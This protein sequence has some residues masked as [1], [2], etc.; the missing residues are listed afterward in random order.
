MIA[1]M[2]EYFLCLDAETFLKRIRPA[3]TASWRQRSFYPCRSLCIDL[4]AA[5][6]EYSR[7][8]HT[9]DEETLVARVADGIPFDRDYWRLLAGEVLLFSALEIPEFPSTAET[10]CCLLDPGRE[11]SVREQLAPIQQVLRGSRDVTFGAA[12]YRPDRAGYNDPDDVA[13][14]AA[15]L[16]AVE[17]QRW[18]VDDLRPL[19]DLA[20]DAERADELAFVYEW[21]PVLVELYQRAQ[22]EQRVLIIENIY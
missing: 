16:S 20:D 12:I 6:H 9:G 18:A 19:G 17:P 5:A 7:R 8:Y 15:Y 11:A 10:L 22:A 13:R 4:L 14:L 3:L 2:A 1:T 21:F